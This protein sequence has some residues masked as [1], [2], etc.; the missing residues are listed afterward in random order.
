LKPPLRV[1]LVE[2]SDEDA[3]LVSRE[4]K[5]GFDANIHRVET[6]EEMSTALETKTFDVIVSD[7]SMPRFSGPA[8]FSVLRSKELDIPFIIASGTIGEEVAI[9]TMKLGVQDYLLKDK[10]GRLVPAIER[11]LR[12]AASRKA[13]RLAEENLR[14]SEA[15]FRDLFE[16]APD[17]IV[18]VGKDGFVRLANGAASRIFGHED[19][20]GIAFADLVTR[21][22]ARG[23]RKDGTTIAVEI[24]RAT[25]RSDDTTLVIVRDVTERHALEQRV[26]QKQKLEAIGSLAGGVAHDFNNIMSVILSFSSLITSSLKEGDPIVAD[27][28]EIRKAALRATD[29]TRQLLAFARK[30]VLQPQPLSL[31][32]VLVSTQRMLE[33]MLGEDIE[34]TILPSK[35]LGT[36]MVDPGQV[37][38]VVMN[39]VVNAR[40]AMPS[41]GKLTIETS[42]VEIDEAYASQH[43]G[44]VPGSYVMLAITDT[45]IGMD[46]ATQ[47]HIFEPFFTTKDVGKGTGLG[48]ATVFGIVKQSGGHIWLYSEPGKGTTFK[49]YFPRSDQLA[50]TP[51]V[52]PPQTFR[53]TETILIAEDDDALRTVAMTILRLNG[54]HVLAARNGGDALM[55]CEQHP[56]TIHLLLTD[57]VMPRMSGRQVA[58][59]LTAVRPGMKVLYMSGYTD[60]AIVH[61]GVLDSGVA[62]LQKPIT[63]ESLARK[64]REVLD[65]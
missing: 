46:T 57:V 40:D 44:V 18:V 48:L 29:L 63:P 28:H 9:E 65:G 6:P 21:D 35:D 64:V 13:G 7:Y 39:L 14:A 36:T 17:A 3:E 52:S 60:S 32:D 8:A 12:E 61:H 25:T 24:S 42:N 33:R 23:V 49:V 30:Q 34:L 5:R 55:I 58:D 37:E 56:A 53:G 62:F 2:D 26:R 50:T 31:A 47:A 59:R 4:L 19:L 11:E 54:Y 41:G 15:R 45:G 20:V 16:A 43:A 1:L 10:L 51:S 27:L 38:Q 22:E